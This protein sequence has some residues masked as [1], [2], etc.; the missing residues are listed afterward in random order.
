MYDLALAFVVAC[1]CVG[2][3]EAG[4]YMWH[5]Q[6]LVALFLFGA[7]AVFAIIIAFALILAIIQLF[8][9]K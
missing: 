6:R 2:G 7:T 1:I 5:K 3:Y 4:K 8:M 9:H